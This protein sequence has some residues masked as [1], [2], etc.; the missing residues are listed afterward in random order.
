MRVT[1]NTFPQ[2]F[3][4]VTQRLRERE[5]LAHRNISSGQ[6][7]HQASDDPIAF[8]QGLEIQ[9]GQRLSRQFQDSI[10]QLKA[11]TDS[12]YAAA[13]GLQTVVSRASELTV[14]ANGTLSPSDM[15]NLAAEVNQLLEQ[16]VGM[17]NQ[18]SG[19]QFLFG[20]TSL[21]PGDID[22]NTANPY[23]PFTTT[24]NANNEITAVQY[25]GNEV[26]NR[27]K[28]DTSTT[29]DLNMIGQTAA[30]D[31]PR[32]LFVNGSGATDAN[33]FRTLI[34]LR[35]Q[36]RTG[37]V[38]QSAILAEFHTAEENVANVVG[39]TAANFERIKI[40]DSSASRQLQD[41]AAQFSR[42]ADSDL[43]AEIMNLQQIDQVLQGA[44]QTGGR[45]LD[46]TLLNFLR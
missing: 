31:S 32:G 15:N 39:A 28:I 36:L 25:R 21:Q 38:D 27:I 7:I 10:T 16:V 11:R 45:I 3:A 23:L 5:N 9:S 26:V 46:L 41:S 44:L 30:A 24:L 17:G 2:E 34:T 20:G 35:D 18:Q 8:R 42:V 43:V 33:V 4:A 29:M 13:T 14:R 19:G 1:S 37:T 22:P 40:A 12:N 6:K